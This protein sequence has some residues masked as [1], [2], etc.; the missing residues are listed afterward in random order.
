MD[1]GQT[2]RITD[3]GR[4]VAHEVDGGT[5]CGRSG[6]VVPG[7]LT[8]AEHYA[9]AARAL[10]PANARSGA[11]PSEAA[12]LLLAAAAVAGVVVLL[13][14]L[15][16]K[17]LLHGQMGWLAFTPLVLAVGVVLVAKYPLLGSALVLTSMLTAFVI[18]PLTLKRTQLADE[19]RF[20]AAV[21]EVIAGQER[22]TNAAAVKVGWDMC[23][24]LNSVNGAPEMVFSG[25]DPA[26]T[27][28]RIALDLTVVA[29]SAEEE[30]QVLEVV[31]LADTYLC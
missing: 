20:A 26:L 18:G 6:R 16:A 2:V 13:L 11:A 8:E 12:G 15:L 30:S 1:C 28:A 19:E 7:L 31:H 4:F 3:S 10:L 25:V 21:H 17:P 14:W 24:A 27:V 29:P 9:T 22:L 5:A 23:G